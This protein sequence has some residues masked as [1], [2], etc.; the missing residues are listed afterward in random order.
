MHGVRRIAK[1]EL[2]SRRRSVKNAKGGE[3]AIHPPVAACHTSPTPLLNLHKLSLTL[4][5]ASVSL[6]VFAGIA[7]SGAVFV[8][9]LS[10]GFQKRYKSFCMWGTSH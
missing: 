10:S 5:S 7:E 6:R 8:L 3:A 9:S 4:V 1:P 2:T